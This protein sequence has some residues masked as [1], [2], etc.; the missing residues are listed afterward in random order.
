MFRT[1]IIPV[2][3]LFSVWVRNSQNAAGHVLC[4]TKAVQ[5][6]Y[7]R[8]IFAEETDDG[9]IAKGRT[10]PSRSTLVGP[11][12]SIQGSLRSGHRGWAIQGVIWILGR[13]AFGEGDR[14][15]LRTAAKQGQGT[16]TSPVVRTTWTHICLNVRVAYNR[17][18]STPDHTTWR[19]Q[20]RWQ[21]LSPEGGP[22]YSV[23]C[24][25]APLPCSA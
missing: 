14:N 23:R 19:I 2:T 13:R 10:T 1:T 25:L 22:G 7:T 8:Y 5:S 21:G 20:P 18:V 4:H 12:E 6:L 16:D 11:G 3:S 15:M 24:L 9:C 17:Q